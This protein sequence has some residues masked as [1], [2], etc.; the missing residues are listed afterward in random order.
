MLKAYLMTP[1]GLK[2]PIDQIGE[3]ILIENARMR[4]LPD[5]P[6]AIH[7]R[8]SWKL[9]GEEFVVMQIDGPLFVELQRGRQ[10]RAFGRFEKLWIVD[11]HLLTAMD[12]PEIANFDYKSQQWVCESDKAA[13]D[14]IL[15][16]SA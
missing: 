4:M 5:G 10:S 8:H 13:W 15:F 9:E 16:T 7:G 2:K 12:D 11:G 14:R 1:A 3:S 6:V